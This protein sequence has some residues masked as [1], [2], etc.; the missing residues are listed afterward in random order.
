MENTITPPQKV[1]RRS[2]QSDTRQELKRHDPDHFRD[3][4][5]EQEQK[6]PVDIY[7]DLTDVAMDALIELLKQ[8][9][10]PSQES[11]PEKQEQEDEDEI[12]ASDSTEDPSEINQT[13]L[14]DPRAMQAAQAYQHALET[15]PDR[16]EHV[17]DH[18]APENLGLSSEIVLD[19][20]IVNPVLRDLETLKS[21]GI[22][23]LHLERAEGGGVIAS[24]Q[25][26]IEKLL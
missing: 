26:A 7:E 2:E 13:S 5:K 16:P 10:A 14:V 15:Q 11:V 12:E 22:K 1:I 8:L 21:R 17:H 19:P 20:V 24:I 3:K 25:Q 9:S 6:E 4:D 18:L 23:T